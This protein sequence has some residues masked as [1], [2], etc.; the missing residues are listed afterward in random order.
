MNR[1]GYATVSIGDVESPGRDTTDGEPLTDALGCVATTVEGYRVSE[2]DTVTLPAGEE[3]LC[4]PVRRDGP[5]Y[6]G[7]AHAIPSPGLGQVPAA[8]ECH[9]QCETA[10]GLF[11]VGAPADTEGTPTAVELE[12]CAFTTPDTSDVATARL[13]GTLGCGGMKVNA[14]LLGPGQRVPYHTEGTQE[15]LFVP[16]DGQASMEI[17]DEARETPVG[18]I[19][20]VGPDAPRS[21]CNE[22]E[23]ES[24]WVMIGAPPTGGI[25]EWDPGAEML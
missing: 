20:R 21:A 22:G 11:V 14:R 10:T 7:D 24:L 19:T 16:V 3:Q 6:L 15:E 23:T 8:R 13:T 2:G 17:A 25:D 12:A 9:V 5:V 1:S 4:L 18:T